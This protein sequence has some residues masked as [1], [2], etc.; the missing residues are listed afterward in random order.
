M[1]NLIVR[2]YRESDFAKDIMEFIYRIFDHNVYM[3]MK[4]NLLCHDC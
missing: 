2:I 1:N 4:I 3:S